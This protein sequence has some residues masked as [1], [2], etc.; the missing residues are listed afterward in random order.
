M[1]LV[2]QV[3]WQTWHFYG[4]A[5][6]LGRSDPDHWFEIHAAQTLRLNRLLL[7]TTPCRLELVIARAHGL[8]AICLC[9]HAVNG[10]W[11]NNH[12]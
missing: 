1:Q 12:W 11:H 4:R 5:I 2:Q 9:M 10:F 7:S 8:M 6:M 3:I